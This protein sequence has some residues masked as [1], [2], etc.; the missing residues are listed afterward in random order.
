MYQHSRRPKGAQITTVVQRPSSSTAAAS[1]SPT[2]TPVF[3]PAA[4]VAKETAAPSSS[5]SKSK[6]SR[7]SRRS[8]QSKQ[9]ADAAASEAGAAAPEAVAAAGAAAAAGLSAAHSFD[10]PAPAGVP[11][12][13][14]PSPLDAGFSSMPGPWAC[15]ELGRLDLAP[16]APLPDPSA[17]ALQQPELPSI[18]VCVYACGC[19]TQTER[20]ALREDAGR[21]CYCD[22]QQRVA[23][24]E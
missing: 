8:K 3:P 15:G 5:S 21:H 6:P 13:P 14:Q 12:A 18:Q 19:N 1:S 10:L 4:A 7:S 16:L 2:A 24:S 23:G 22:R 11:G 9:Q 17:A 20:A